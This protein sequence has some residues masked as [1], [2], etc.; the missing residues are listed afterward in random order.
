MIPRIPTIHQTL[1]STPYLKDPGV[2]FLAKTVCVDPRTSGLREF[3]TDLDPEFEHGY[4]D[5]TDRDDQDPAGGA[6]LVQLAGQLCYLSFGE[7]RTLFE[8]NASYLRK[9]MEQGHGSVIEHA[10]YTLLFYG[11]DRACTHELV[12]H[13]AGMAY[14]QVSQRYVDGRHLRFV[15]PYEYQS[16]VTLIQEFEAE[17]DHAAA[18]YEARAE[19]LKE[20]FPKKAD[21]SMTDW[22]KRIQS[23]AR[24]SLPNSTEAPIVVTGNARAWRHV[25]SMRCSKYADVR[26]RRPMFRALQLLQAQDANM[27]KD[28]REV[29]LKDGSFGAET[30]FP[31][32]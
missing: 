17:I 7:K 22:R 9:I 21:E 11:I 4:D 8:E 2:I 14:S 16:H 25:L 10:N 29:E 12:R 18:T 15:M 23:C 28:F 6:E 20:I 30:D 26:I 5:F 19:A 32:P 1:G 24:E 3:M 13:R 27:F 31:K